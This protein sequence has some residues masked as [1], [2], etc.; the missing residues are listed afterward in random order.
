MNKAPTPLGAW[1]LWPQRDKRL[2]LNWRMFSNGSFPNHWTASVWNKTSR[3]IQ[4]EPSSATGWMAPVSLFAAITETRI[5]SFRMAS[6]K[7]F[8]STNPSTSTGSVVSSK[9][10]LFTR[11]SKVWRTA[12]CSTAEV[13]R[14][15]PLA[16]NNRAEPHMAKLLL[17]VPP[18]VK[19]TSLGLH[20]HTLETR[21]RQSSKKA[22]ALRPIW[23]ILDG[24]PKD[25]PNK[26]IIA[27]L[28]FSSRGVVAL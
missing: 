5:V 25:S 2:A 21:S 16:F 24:F 9:P 22:R 18:L 26:G 19:T 23:W 17:S 3:S 20:F 8:G 1:N 13:M 14:W 7:S 6:A 28:T 10:S 11:Y 15:R 12:W 4:M 27:S